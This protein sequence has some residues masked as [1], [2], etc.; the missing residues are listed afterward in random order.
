MK[1]FYLT[2]ASSAFIIKHFFL[3]LFLVTISVSYAQDP[4]GTVVIT[5]KALSQVSPGVD[6]NF[7]SEFPLGGSI[8]LNDDQSFIPIQDVA[9]ARN[10]T[11]WVIA[12][13]P[14][15]TG[16]GTIYYRKAGSSSWVQTSSSG[17]RIDVTLNGRA[18]MI[19][20]QGFMF[21]W[22]DDTGFVPTTSATI[23]ALDIGASAGAIQNVFVLAKTNT[24][25]NVLK[26]Y[27]GIG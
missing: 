15:G 7:Y 1:S 20:E 4:P 11:I 13:T 18:A 5:K 6:F 9:I 17:A 21:L 22:A 27:T 16:N 12:A 10:N 14:S 24:T 26:R 25:C 23:G 3:L 19:N 8:V 2:H